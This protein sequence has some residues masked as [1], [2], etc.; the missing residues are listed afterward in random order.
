MLLTVDAGNSNI[1]AG[2]FEYTDIISSFRIKTDYHKSFDEYAVIFTQL[3]ENNN[4]R[5]TD[6]EGCIIASVAPGLL[7]ILTQTVSVYL[8]IEPLIVNSK[9]QTG[10]EITC[11]NP[12]EIGVDRIANVVGAF[13]KYSNASIV[14]D[15][16]TATTFDCVSSDAEFLGG[17]IAPGFLTAADALFLKAPRLPRVEYINPQNAIG[18]NTTESLQSGLVL[19]YTS[20]VDGMIER[21]MYEMN[22]ETSIIATG[23]LS[24]TVSRVSRYIED[25]DEYLTLRGLRKIFEL[26][27]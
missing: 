26:N 2:I 21:I 10:I 23:G 18:K 7:D 6:L 11:S 25:V 27:V 16:G 9:I 12:P 19:G 15:F 13:E 8:G 3:L 14:V 5:I 17:V 4:I 24:H 1:V 20:M 22:T